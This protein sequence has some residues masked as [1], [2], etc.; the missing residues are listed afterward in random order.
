MNIYQRFI[1]V[2]L[3]SALAASTYATATRVWNNAAGSGKWANS[4]NSV[5]IEVR[6]GLLVFA[7]A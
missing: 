1:I 3:A 5:T 4:G 7:G 2:A 6:S